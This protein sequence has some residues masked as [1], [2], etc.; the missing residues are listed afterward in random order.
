VS[1]ET[2]RWGTLDEAADI[3]GCSTRTVRRFI[4]AGELTKY[5]LGPRLIKV[6]L[7]EL[8]ALLV[9]ITQGGVAQKI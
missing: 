9:P 4:E 5:R 6:D 3:L 7:N 8:D 2:R 1:A